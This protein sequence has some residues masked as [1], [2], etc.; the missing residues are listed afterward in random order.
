MTAARRQPLRRLAAK[1][2][3]QRRRHCAA[4][5]AADALAKLRAY[6]WSAEQRPRCT[7]R[8][9]ALGNAAD[10]RHDVLQ[11]ARPLLGAD[12]LCG[13][14][15]AAGQRAPAT[16]VRRR[17]GHQGL[18]ASPSATARPTACRPP[19]STTTRSAARR[20]GSSPCRPHQRPG[21]LRASTPR[22]ASAPWSPGTDPVT[23]AALTA[24]YDA[25]AAQS[26]GG[27][28]RHRRSAAERQPARQAHAD[29]RRP[30]RRAG[31]GEQQRRAPTPP[32][33]ARSKAR[34]AKLRYVEVDQRPAL[35]HLH[36]AA[37]LRHALRAAA[38][39]LHPGDGRDVR[40][41]EDGA[42]LP[43]SQVVRTTP[44]GGTPG[45][46]PAI[47]A[48]NVPPTSAAP[49]AGNADR[50]QRHFAVGSQLEKANRPGDFR[51]ESSMSRLKSSGL[52]SP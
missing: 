18:R 46:A 50:V 25:H 7:T 45:A 21:R 35:R 16:S 19:W 26:A 4:D 34:R 8:T 22:C 40:A 33:T 24:T 13:M 39:L 12:N 43:P 32:S 11:R 5:Q 38:R 10:R 48:A 3:G 31:A 47:T 23:G 14:S 29:R 9:T 20:P 6:G 17:R 27:A 41:P 36:P 2:P 28:R 1:R 44:R 51:E 30:Q 42:A 15:F 37:R 49:A 52:K